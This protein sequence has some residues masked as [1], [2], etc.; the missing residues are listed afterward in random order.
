M[1]KQFAVIGLG[2]FGSAVAETLAASGAEVLAIDRAEAKVKPLSDV[3]TIAVQCDATDE[4]ALR[5][6]GVQNVD[7][8]V[9]S[10]GENIEASILVVMLLKEFGIKE[11]VA[12]AVNDL[13]G[14][15]LNHIGVNRVVYPERD[16][17]KR[18]AQSL[19]RPE[20]LE[21]I[22]LSPEYS[23]VEMPAPAF[24][25][26]KTIREANLRA[27]Y[28][29]SIIAIKKQYFLEGAKKETW[30]INPHPDD[31]I[32]KEDLLVVLGA[33]KDIEKLS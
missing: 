25:W 18:V 21:Q 13:H 8:A 6:A 17:A 27:E 16:M 24:T 31:I 19:I 15:I 22:V 2:R 7:V 5:E 12:K 26:N 29:V 3:V 28:G 20:F 32:T 4:K 11:I 10:I 33:N 23:I 14:K 9:V 30:N 1:K